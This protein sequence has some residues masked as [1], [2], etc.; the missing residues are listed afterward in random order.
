MW[1]FGSDPKSLEDLQVN[2]GLTYL[3]I[4]HDLGVVKHMC[5]SV[6]VMYM[7]KVVEHANRSNSL[8]RL[9]IPTQKRSLTQFQ[10]WTWRWT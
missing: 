3:F 5:D 10:N 1:L 4:S 8:L 2:L 9:N 7:G 6:V